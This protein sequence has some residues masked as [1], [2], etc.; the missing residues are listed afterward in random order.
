MLP[1]KS[2]PDL[3]FSD[4]LTETLQAQKLCFGCPQLEECRE[5]GKDEEHGVWGGTTATGRQ[6]A[7]RLQVIKATKERNEKLK[8]LKAEGRSISA[9]AREMDMARSSVT[10]ILRQLAA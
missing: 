5:L 2:N 3:F 9:I 7:R 10:F 4:N 6:E 8:A 1:C